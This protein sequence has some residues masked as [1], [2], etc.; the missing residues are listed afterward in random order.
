MADVK[1]EFDGVSHGVHCTWV[2]CEDA[3]GGKTLKFVGYFVRSRN[4]LAGAQHR[5]FS[6]IQWRCTGVAI[7]P[8][9]RDVEPLEGLY[10]YIITS[11]RPALEKP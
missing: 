3:G 7:P 2:R 1:S 9:D 8:L 4:Q 5:V 10:A 11:Q 6:G